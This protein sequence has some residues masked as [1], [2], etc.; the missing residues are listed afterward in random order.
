MLKDRT[1]YPTTAPRQ[2]VRSLMFRSGLNKRLGPWWWKPTADAPY[3]E[4]LVRR[5]ARMFEGMPTA[6]SDRSF[7]DRVASDTARWSEVEDTVTAVHDAVVEPNRCHVLGPDGRMVQQFDLHR[8]LHVY[9]SAWQYARRRI[10]HRLERAVVFDG[11]AG[12]NLWH[13]FTDSLMGLAWLDEEPGLLPADV[14][15]I[16]NRRIANHPF[17]RHLRSCS[18]RFDTIPWV[19]LEPGEF[20]QVGAAYRLNPARFHRGL[21]RRIRGYYG[22]KASSSARRLFVSRDVKRFGRGLS[23]EAEIIETLS[24]YGFEPFYAERVSVAE[25]QRTFEDCDFIVGLHG[26]A[27]AQQ[28][29]MLPGQGRLLELMPVSRPQ[30]E[31]TWQSWVL[32]RQAYD[33]SVGSRLDSQLCYRADPADIRF[34]LERM[35]ALPP[36][37]TQFG[38]TILSRG[39]LT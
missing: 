23:N 32:E 27:L 26:M 12:R 7:S 2:L 35:L 24:S 36:D 25:Q 38:E 29:F 28:I 6:F 19:V 9:P 4:T 17:F 21:W 20:A 10:A 8:G 31:Y 3:I 1:D 13:F 16:V 30:T 22:A 18:E 11:S 5:Q 39:K 37:E 15:F 14:P 33:V 34:K